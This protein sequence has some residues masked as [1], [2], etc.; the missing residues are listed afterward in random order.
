MPSIQAHQGL[1]SE[2]TRAI[3]DVPAVL[4]LT[5]ESAAHS[6]TL[7]G[8]G[9]SEGSLAAFNPLFEDGDGDAASAATQRRRG[10]QA[11]P[12]PGAAVLAFPCPELQASLSFCC[13]GCASLEHRRKWSVSAIAVCVCDSGVDSGLCWFQPPPSIVFCA[14]YRACATLTAH[15]TRMQRRSMVPRRRRISQRRW[16][17][18]RGSSMPT[19]ACKRC[20]RH[21]EASSPPRRRSL[22]SGTPPHTTSLPS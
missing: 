22:P 6:S 11:V 16:P 13:F 3:S 8:T 5:G 17:P 1:D 9:N 12:L 19:A 14:F 10:V 4:A 15:W 18:P 20:V 21:A 2:H 7:T